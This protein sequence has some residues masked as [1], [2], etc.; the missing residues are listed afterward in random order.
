MITPTQILCLGISHRTAPVALR[1]HFRCALDDQPALLHAFGGGLTRLEHGPFAAIQELVI[2]STCNRMELYAAVDEAVADA[3]ALIRDFLAQT[4]RVDTAGFIPYLYHFNGVQAAEHLFRVAAGLDSLV[5]GEPQ[6]LGQVNDAFLASRQTYAAGPVLSALFQAAVR[7]GKRARTETSISSNPASVSSVSLALAQEIVGDLQDKQLLLVG[8]GEMGQLSLKALQARG[9]RRLAVA[10]RNP[11][12]AQEAA[13]R[14]G[15]RVYNLAQLPQAL[16]EADVVFS[17][18]AANTPI[19]DAAMV[20]GA[21][22]CR[23][24]RPL[25]IV[26]MAMPRDV[27]PAAGELPGVHL[28]DIDSLQSSLDHALEAR[29]QE[30]PKVEAII[31]QELELLETEWRTLAVRPLIVDLRQKAEAIRRRELEKTLR[32]LRHLEPEL[33]EHVN[34]LSLSLVNKLLHEPTLR[35]K[36]KAVAADPNDYAATVRELFGLSGDEGKNGSN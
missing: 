31:R 13:A 27:A 11:E 36:E 7:T 30:A 21:L 29:R 22:E 14:Y 8:L 35:L 32:N 3:P 23:G 2:L 9:A 12:R 19:I 6:I 15:C 25:V 20:Q 33:L 24:G 16:A 26:D 18:T 34:Q 4:H 28:F 17:A 5:L 1:E 10:N